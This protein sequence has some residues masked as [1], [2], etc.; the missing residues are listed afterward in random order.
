LQQSLYDPLTG[1]CRDAL[2]ADRIN[3]NEGAEST[4]SFLLAL[5]EMRADEVRWN[6]AQ[7]TVDETMEG[8]MAVSHAQ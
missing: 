5:V 8:A 7:K 1:G 3:E 6:A 4:L 2:H